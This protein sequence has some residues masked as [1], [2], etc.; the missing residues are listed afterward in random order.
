M[1]VHIPT[2]QYGFIEAEVETPQEAKELSDEI[3]SAFRERNGQGLDTKTFNKVIER[4]LTD[5]TMEADMYAGM[6]KE[7]IDW[8]QVTKRAFARIKN[9]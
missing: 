7:Q 9:R 2:E 6:N 1:K 4:Y 8:V 3:K 5:G